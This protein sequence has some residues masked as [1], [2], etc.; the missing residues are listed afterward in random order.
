M[1]DKNKNKIKKFKPEKEFLLEIVDKRKRDKRKEKA[2][3]QHNKK[4]ED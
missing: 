4:W 2:K 1:K 3:K